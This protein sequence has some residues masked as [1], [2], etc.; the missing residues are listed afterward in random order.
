MWPTGSQ[1]ITIDPADFTTGASDGANTVRGTGRILLFIRQSLLCGC[2]CTED[3][4]SGLQKRKR[5]HSEWQGIFEFCLNAFHRIRWINLLCYGWFRLPDSDSDSKPYG[6]ITF[7]IRSDPDSDPF[8]IVFYSAG[9]RVRVGI[10]VWI[11]QC[12]SS[13]I[14]PQHE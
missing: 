6:Y 2:P 14:L 12:K 5:F 8:P 9:I 1:V 3:R 7:H 4:G 11:R 10:R 13:R